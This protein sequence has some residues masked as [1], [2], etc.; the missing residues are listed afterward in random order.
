M[1]EFP[2]ALFRGWHDLNDSR[3][4]WSES[5]EQEARAEGYAPLPACVEGA[6]QQEEV[7][8]APKKRPG[9]PKKVA[10]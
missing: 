3:L 4:A 9:R 6:Q 10:E 7:A 5:E 8:E 1:K 2:K